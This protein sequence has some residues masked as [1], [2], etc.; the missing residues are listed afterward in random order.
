MTLA[1]LNLLIKARN[2]S[3]KKQQGN[4]NDLLALQRMANRG[5]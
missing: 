5:N 4:V 2:P 1:Q 3:P